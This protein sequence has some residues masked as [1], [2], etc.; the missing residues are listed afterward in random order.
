VRPKPTEPVVAALC[1][2]AEKVQDAM[3]GVDVFYALLAVTFP[4]PARL[5]FLRDPMGFDRLD[6]AQLT[7]LQ[8]RALQAIGRSPVWRVEP[9]FYGRLMDLGLDYGLPW[10][11]KKYEEYLQTAEHVVG[12]DPGA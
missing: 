5:T 1:R 8:L 10:D 2:A 4:K 6:P 3:A 9:F 12:K 7:P 11:P